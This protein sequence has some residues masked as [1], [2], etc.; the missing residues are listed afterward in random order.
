MGDFFAGVLGAVVT[1]LVGLAVGAIIQWLG[2]RYWNYRQARPIVKLFG[3]QSG[4]VRVVHSSIFDKERDAYNYPAADSQASRILAVL[5]SRAHRREGVGL[6]VSADVELIK[7]GHVDPALW[8]E[9]LILLCGPKRNPLVK[10]AL[11]NL[12]QNLKYTMSVD[13]ATGRTMLRDN[14]RGHWL[15]SSTDDK[16][17][18]NTP[19]GNYDYGLILSVQN[20]FHEGATVTILAG[21]HGTG[22]LGCAAFLKDIQNIK[23]LL[24]RRDNGIICEVVKVYYGDSFEE[25]LDTRLA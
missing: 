24:D 12:P 2:L 1:G 16:A 10:D 9:N 14:N 11:A 22:T 23:K 25:V 5:L 6:T 7:G 4:P 3:L 20:A 18:G 17:A 8:K 19:N 15:S 21:L 13:P